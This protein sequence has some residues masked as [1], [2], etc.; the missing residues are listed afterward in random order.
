MWVKHVSMSDLASLCLF[1]ILFC[2]AE[3]I[4]FNVWPSDIF[5]L[6]FPRG[7]CLAFMC[8]CVRY[9][10][11][12]VVGR[13]VAHARS[14]QCMSSACAENKERMRAHRGP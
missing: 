6:R 4:M 11:Q 12:R 14:M 13:D 5:K 3:F 9:S 2:F 1:D 8:V 10:V 7:D